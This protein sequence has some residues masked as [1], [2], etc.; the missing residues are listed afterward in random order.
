MVAIAPNGANGEMLAATIIT[1]NDE[2]RLKL[3]EKFKKHELSK[4]QVLSKVTNNV[5]VMCV[6]VVCGVYTY[7][8]CMYM[9]CV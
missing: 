6:Y 8:L 4:T 1:I 5:C 3:T 2:E 9:L 7:V